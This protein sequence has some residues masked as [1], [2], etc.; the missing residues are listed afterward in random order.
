MG[1]LDW[2]R[3]PVMK[4]EYYKDLLL[5]GYG[6]IAYA[7]FCSETQ[8][9]ERSPKKECSAILVNAPYHMRCVE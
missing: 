1:T 3:V 9:L 2:S 6:I 5:L 4:K 7:L 8:F